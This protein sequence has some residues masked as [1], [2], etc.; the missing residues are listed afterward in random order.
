MIRSE[1]RYAWL[2]H[3]LPQ[4]ELL[5]PLPAHSFHVAQTEGPVAKDLLELAAVAAE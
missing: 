4:D 3:A 5:R 1:D 2:D